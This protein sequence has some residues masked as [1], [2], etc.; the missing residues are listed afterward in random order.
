MM[1][2]QHKHVGHGSNWA[3][4]IRRSGIAV[5]AIGVIGSL[6]M[7]ASGCDT[8]ALI[9]F[10]DRSFT[11]IHSSGF[12]PP[13][14][15]PA[16]PDA[17]AGVGN[18]GDMRVRF[19]L[20]DNNGGP[21]R[22]GEAVDKTSVE[23]SGDS[24]EMANSALMEVSDSGACT[25]G[26][27]CSTGF[28]C[29][30]APEL[31]QDATM[32]CVQP[33]DAFTVPSDS[34]AVQFVADVDEHQVYGLLMENSGSLTGWNPPGSGNSWDKN[35]D[36]DTADPEDAG[37]QQGRLGRTIATDFKVDR[38]GAVLKAQSSW[39]TA[40]LLAK[41]EGRKTLFGL[42]SFNETRLDPTSHVEPNTA[43]DS[44]WTEDGRTVGQAITDYQSEA[45]VG[46]RANVYEAMNNLIDEQYT[47]QAMEDRGLARPGSVDKQLVVFVD[48]YDDMRENDGVNIDG[49]IEKATQNNVRLF[50]V[51]LDPKLD[52]PESLREDPLYPSK[53]DPCTDD[54]TCKNYEVCAKPRGY[55]APGDDDVTIP[56][57]ANYDLTKTY[58]IPRRDDFGR[59]GPIDD[60]ARLACAT[61]G[62]YMYVPSVEA[63]D[64]NL[65][66]TPLALDGLWEAKVES[67]AIS[68][69]NAQPGAPLRIHS[70][71]IVNVTGNS[72]TYQFSQ[73]GNLST[74]GDSNSDDF[75][76][77][78]V[79]FTAE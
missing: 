55:S 6:A 22:L 66:W 75:D 4:K 58:C 74:G 72:R 36:G 19:V 60:Y 29:S 40:Y 10:S 39:I 13:Q 59:T 53:Q 33:D 17:C 28:S 76:S 20:A 7:A 42:W 35:A 25:D 71:M 65:S 32:A 18:D 61:G 44:H 23:L 14:S 77:R 63:I 3:D 21:I 34:E 69:G 15:S 41:E 11:N 43:N 9:S 5:A 62:G 49:L 56:D 54:S 30:T 68:R 37:A 51:H 45:E 73:L 38:F 67:G 2:R 47:R 57:G 31:P 12:T 46:S 8:V 24:V 64:E 50:I 27:T 52:E 1:K 79:V 78:G 16:N 26:S 48:G 70:D